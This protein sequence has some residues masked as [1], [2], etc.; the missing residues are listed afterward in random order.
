MYGYLVYYNKSKLINRSIATGFSL[1]RSIII[2]VL[3]KDPWA[4]LLR[5][6]S[7]ES[8]AGL[9]FP[10]CRVCKV[11][12]HIPGLTT[13]SRTSGA[14]SKSPLTQNISKNSWFDIL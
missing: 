5:T 10:V 3:K 13:T 12:V 14:S 4:N 9:Y 11:A 2:M 7:K 6:L 8:R 1:T